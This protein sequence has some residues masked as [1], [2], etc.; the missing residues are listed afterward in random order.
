MRIVA[1]AVAT[2]L[3]LPA[4]A[5]ADAVIDAVNDERAAYDLPPLIVS[6]TLE[7][8]STSLARRLMREQRFDHDL[9]RPPG[10]GRF[11][12]ALM[13]DYTRR[14]DPATAVEAWMESPEHRQVLLTRSMRYVGAGATR[15]DF[16]GERATLR[17]LQVGRPAARSHPPSTAA[18]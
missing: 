12:E 11:G 6:Q 15:G 3:L 9:L 13:L 17:V 10:F 1:A 16:E 5:R 8:T 2:L 4:S 14:A 7:R 18:R